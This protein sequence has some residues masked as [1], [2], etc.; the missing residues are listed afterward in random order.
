MAI[1]VFMLV[2]ALHNLIALRPNEAVCDVA[3]TGVTNMDKVELYSIDLRL[4]G[5]YDNLDL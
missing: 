3:T 4:I 1:Q 2:D 5:Y